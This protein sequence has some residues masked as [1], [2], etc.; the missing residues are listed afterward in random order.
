MFIMPIATVSLFTSLIMI[1]NLIW[2]WLS[3]VLDLINRVRV[4][5]FSFDWSLPSFDW[6]FINT[7]VL[8]IVIMTV[9]A[10]TLFIIYLS[11]RLAEGRFRIHKGIFY[12]MFL[13]G[14]L[15]PLWLVKALASTLLKREVSWR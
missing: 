15:A 1:G 11:V 4:V 7:G 6:Y 5:G 8:P 13:Y 10:L 9:L 2:N 14:F 12:Y 3:E